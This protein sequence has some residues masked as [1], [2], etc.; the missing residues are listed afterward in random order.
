MGRANKLILALKFLWQR[1]LKPGPRVLFSKVGKGCKIHPTAIV[2]ASK[3]GDGCE[4]GAYAIV[5]ASVLGPGCTIEDGAHVQ[6]CVLDEGAHVGRQTAVFTCYLMEGSHSTQTMMQ[7]SVLGRH[8]ATTRASWFQDT[9]FDGKHMR[10]EPP[11]T[12]SDAGLLDSGTRFLGCDVGHETMVGADV[13]VAAGRMLPSHAKV[14]ADPLRTASK[15]DSA[16]DVLDAG[17]DVLVV[18]DGRLEPLT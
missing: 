6:M 3:L 4:I 16:I 14:I 5:R 13:F 12:E 17:G 1:F 9:R 18:R 2:E 11:P 10:V 7:M 15:L 8:A